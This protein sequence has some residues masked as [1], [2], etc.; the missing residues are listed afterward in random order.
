MRSFLDALF[1]LEG[2]TAIVTG[3]A[4]YLGKGFSETLLAAGASVVLYGRGEK[5]SEFA[6]SLKDRYGKNVSHFQV[7]FYDEVRFSRCLQA[8]GS[9]IDILVNN[10]YDFS[11]KTGFNCSS[12]RIEN[13]EKKTWMK[14]LE[15]GICWAS[16]AIGEVLGGMKRRKNGSIINVSSIY[17]LVAPDPGLYEGTETFNPLHYGASK[18]GLIA[19]TKYVASFYGEYGIRCN[20]LVPGAFPN[21]EGKN[22]PAEGIVDKLKE[23]TV[24]GRIGLP[25]DLTGALIF[26]AS[27]AS[28]YM[29]GQSLVID[30]G[31]TTR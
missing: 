20:A 10:A 3:A 9:E 1:S 18:A 7:D 27:D 26:L 12:G 11:E 15:S 2:K 21:A 17:A 23:K 28:S 25:N 16:L 8:A 6:R 29:T 31:W 4:G 5:L 30:G 14:G 24:L 22:E 13:M 19:L